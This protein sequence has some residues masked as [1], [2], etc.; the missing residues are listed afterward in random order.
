MLYYGSQVSVSVG[1]LSVGTSGSVS[2]D[3]S[4]ALL[5]HFVC[6]FYYNMFYFMLSYFT[7]IPLFPVCLLM[8]CRKVVDLDRQ[9][10][11]P[12]LGGVEEEKTRIGIYSVRK[13]FH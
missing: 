9:E 1:F 10:G 6:F 3:F 11:G 13:Y 8:R 7:I 12:E 4:W 2:Y 5:L